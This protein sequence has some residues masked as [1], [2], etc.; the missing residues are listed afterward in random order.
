MIPTLPGSDPDPERRS[1]QLARQRDRYVFRYQEQGLAGVE[2]LPLSEKDDLAY[3]AAIAKAMAELEVNRLAMT[4]PAQKVEAVARDVLGT[5]AKLLPDELTSRRRERASAPESSGIEAYAAMFATIETPPIVDLWQRDD[6]FAWQAVAGTNPVMLRRMTGRLENLRL[7]DAHVNRALGTG[8]SVDRAVGEGRLYATDYAM[9]DGLPDGEVDGLRKFGFAPI[10]VYASV[11]T[12]LVPVAI[13]TTQRPGRLFGP[14]DGVSWQMART[15]VSA[16]DGNVQGIVTHFALCHQVM[17]GV[18]LSA[19]RQLSEHH[20]LFVLISPHFRD[21]LITNDIAWSSLINPNGHMDRLQS[22]TLEASLT[23]ARQ[24]LEAF[25]LLDGVPAIDG[26]ARGIDDVDALPVC[27]SRDDALLIYAAIEAW[28]DGYVRLYYHRDADVVADTELRA[29]VDEMGSDDGGR[30]RGIDRPTTV[31][32]VTRLVAAILWRCTA[33]HASIN[34]SSFPLFSYAPNVQT[35][36]F[37]PGPTGGPEDTR[38]AREAMIPPWDQAWEAFS[39]FWDITVRLDRMDGYGD[40][41]FADERVTPLLEQYRA[42][43]ADAERTLEA[44]DTTRLMAYPWMRPSRV[45]MS[46]QV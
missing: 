10:A 40:E 38:A 5:F 31:E 25:R 6:I 20:P 36:S 21:T 7:T 12:G 30:L 28:V 15:C 9:L 42:S 17:E 27:P 4:T 8:W 26:A 35:A 39:L 44:R 3:W 22:P 23:L 18:I 16:A 46:I 34:Y 45:P 19:H 32:D 29:F 24:E 43:L 14:D 33:F 11:P 1:R 41:H 13:Q 37:G 2:A